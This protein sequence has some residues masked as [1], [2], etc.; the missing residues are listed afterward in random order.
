[1]V[2]SNFQLLDF[3]SHLFNSMSRPL[4]K[5]VELTPDE[6]A[7]IMTFLAAHPKRCEADM[8]SANEAVRAA[9]ADIANFLT[10]DTDTL[11]AGFLNTRTE[12]LKCA[13]ITAKVRAGNALKAFEIATGLIAKLTPFV[14]PAG[15]LGAGAPPA[16]ALGAVALSA[17]AGVVA[18]A[19]DPTG[20][21]SAVIDAGAGQDAE[22][23]T[24]PGAT[25][26]VASAVIDAGAGQ[27]AEPATPPVA[28]PPAVSQTVLNSE[29]MVKCMKRF[30]SNSNQWV[31][32]T[33]F[34]GRPDRDM[35]S[36]C[37]LVAQK[38]DACVYCCSAWE[39]G[40]WVPTPPKFPVSF[41]ACEHCKSSCELVGEFIGTVASILGAS[42]AGSVAGQ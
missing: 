32:K 36:C 42:A 14:P 35:S 15:A 27:D 16:A 9:N 11:L 20:V 41:Q 24:P 22:P 8:M 6:I 3:S 18:G 12:E 29:R 1:L 19:A 26:G 39:Q 34:Y 38:M 13:V 10:S 4:S 25:T 33:L 28:D 21:A 5:L 37:K 23:A 40:S 30:G 17:V 7:L 31:L 2:L